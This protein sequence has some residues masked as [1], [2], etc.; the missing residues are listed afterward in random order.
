LVLISATGRF[1]IHQKDD[2]DKSQ[3]SKLIRPSVLQH[4]ELVTW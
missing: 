4:H 3:G 1:W 2:W